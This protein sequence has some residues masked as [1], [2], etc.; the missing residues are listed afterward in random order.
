MLIHVFHDNDISP[1]ANEPASD[2]AWNPPRN[3]NGPEAVLYRHFDSFCDLA[4]M[5]GS[6]QTNIAPF[7]SGKVIAN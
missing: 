2:E 4:V 6:Q 7:V 1:L 5:E 3:W